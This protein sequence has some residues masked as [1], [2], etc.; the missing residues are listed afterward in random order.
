MNIGCLLQCQRD[1]WGDDSAGKAVENLKSYLRGKV[2]PV[3]GMC[4][5]FDI[6]DKYQR[7]RMVQFAYHLFP[8]FFYDRDFDFD[9]ETVT[10]LVAQTQSRIGGYGVSM[11][12]SACEDIDS[13]DMLIRLHP[14]VD[15]NLES[16]IDAQLSKAFSWVCYNQVDDGGF[17]FRLGEPFRYG[18]AETS[19]IVSEGAGLP[20]WF[21][22]LS[23]AYLADLFRLQH[24]FKL[25]PCP[26]YEF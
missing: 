25:T 18:S 4:G 5:Y 19:A 21:R 8:I 12:S 1:T 24:N 20:T 14:F 26:G 16:R 10:R 6:R 2:N 3:T 7:S 15:G 17:V 9:V 22:V 23:L 13:I 11:N